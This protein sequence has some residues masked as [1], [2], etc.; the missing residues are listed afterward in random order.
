MVD[1]ATR[2]S[3]ALPADL[4]APARAR[5]ALVPLADG[6]AV[7]RDHLALLT[8]E[9]VTNALR[10]AGLRAGD[11]IEVRA[12]RSRGRV[13]VEVLDTGRSGAVPR[14]RTGRRSLEATGGFGLRLVDA[15][16]DRWGAERVPGD[17]TR[18]WFELGA[19]DG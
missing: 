18:A 3:L 13:R 1:D 12:C 19:P 14:M 15:V 5:A 16:A 11:R 7:L 2:S 10:H 9:L 6:D 8:T 4:S 17:G